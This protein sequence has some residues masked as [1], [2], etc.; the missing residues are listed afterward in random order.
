M[1]SRPQGTQ[2]VCD[3]VPMSVCGALPGPEC[4]PSCWMDRGEA[5]VSCP[6]VVSGLWYMCL[7]SRGR[8]SGFIAVPICPKD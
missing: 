8:S 3:Q 7:Q 5:A 4:G 1:A 6:T 2:A